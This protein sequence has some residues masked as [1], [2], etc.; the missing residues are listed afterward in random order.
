MPVS[1]SRLAK[2]WLLFLPLFFLGGPVCF[3]AHYYQADPRYYKGM[4]PTSD[5][6]LGASY[7]AFW[8]LAAG[9][10]IV[11]HGALPISDPFALASAKTPWINGEWLYQILLYGVFTLGGFAGVCWAH[12]LLRATIFSLGFACSN[13]LTC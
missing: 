3:L 4:T 5:T 8:N 11:E 2:E 7:D 12:S 10:W 9:R 1:K 13:C 6:A